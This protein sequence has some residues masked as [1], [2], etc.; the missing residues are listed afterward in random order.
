MDLETFQHKLTSDIAS[1]V[2]KQG[3]RV[4]VFAL[5]GTRRWYML[6]KQQN[7]T[8]DGRQ[9]FEEVTKQLIELCKMI[10]D[11][12]ITTL[13]MPIIS[14]YLLKERGPEYT[15]LVI[16]S[17]GKLTYGDEYRQFYDN[18]EVRVGFY[19]DFEAIGDAATNDHIARQFL[20]VSAETSSHQKNRLFWG[21]C[22]HDATESVATLAVKYFQDHG[23]VPSKSE[24]IKMYYGEPV[25][26]VDLFISS[27]KPRAFD[28]PLISSGRENLYFTVTPSPYLTQDG[29]RKILHDHLYNRS[30]HHDIDVAVDSNSLRDF[31]RA[32]KDNI[33]GVGKIN[34]NWGFW[35]PD[36]MH[37][38]MSE[39]LSKSFLGRG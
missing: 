33:V 28:M 7:S 3:P 17:L 31:Y 35:Q 24:L 11:H 18:Y 14:P 8:F 20:Q 6:E 13:V 34:K 15:Q 29:F 10:Y 25:S 37:T 16:Q 30:G 26:D 2:K 38:H 4:C 19:G 1:I 9:Y 39:K 21:V 5:N 32:N 23:R 22:G 27:G 12:G 36:V